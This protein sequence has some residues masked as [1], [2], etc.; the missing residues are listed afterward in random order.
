MSRGIIRRIFDLAERLE[1]DRNIVWDWLFHTRIDVLDGYTPLEL[2]FADQG[3]RVLELLQS[4]L[5]DEAQT[6]RQ[7]FLPARTG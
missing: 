4:A 1:P 5:S 2:V 7:T 3:G 6:P